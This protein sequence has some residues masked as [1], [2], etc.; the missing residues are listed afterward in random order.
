MVANIIDIR[1]KTTAT[2]TDQASLRDEVL[3]G[4]SKP[5]GQRTLP[6]ML[7]YDEKG[8]QLYDD[9]TVHAPE[10][11]LFS[12][13]EEILKKHA[14]QDIVPAMLHGQTSSANVIELGAGSVI[15]SS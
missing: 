9:I 13:E 5:A 2:T 12:A 4:L 15:F 3:A 7:L 11:Y 8:L 14:K 1:P 10:Y 6:T